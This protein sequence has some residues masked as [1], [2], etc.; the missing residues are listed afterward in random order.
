MNSVIKDKVTD[1]KLIN[2]EIIPQRLDR[3]ELVVDGATF[4]NGKDETIPEHDVKI[5]RAFS[6][7][8][9]SYVFLIFDG[10]AKKYRM[11]QNYDVVEEKQDAFALTNTLKDM[12]E[13]SHIPIITFNYCK[14]DHETIELNDAYKLSNDY[15]A[16]NYL[17]S[18]PLWFIITV[19]SSADDIRGIKDRIQERIDALDKYISVD[20]KTSDHRTI[21][22]YKHGQPLIDG[23]ETGGLKSDF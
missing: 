10:H 20:I 15:D 16:S 23:D 3:N 13:A 12:M 14:F 2:T 1:V 8:L 5:F 4:Y 7:K 9:D 19:N 11:V 17:P 22:F 6:N 21:T 18:G